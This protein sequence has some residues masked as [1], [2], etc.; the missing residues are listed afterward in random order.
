MCSK[1]ISLCQA[2]NNFFDRD[3]GFE[4]GTVVRIGRENCS[5]LR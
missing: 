3:R 5:I 2:E 1:A 4:E